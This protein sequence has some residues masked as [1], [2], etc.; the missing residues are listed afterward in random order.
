MDWNMALG[1][2]E[3]CSVCWMRGVHTASG[4]AV[5]GPPRGCWLPCGSVGCKC[6]AGTGSCLP[7]IL[8]AVDKSCWAALRSAAVPWW[9]F[10]TIYRCYLILFT[11]KYGIRHINEDLTQTDRSVITTFLFKIYFILI[12]KIINVNH[13]MVLEGKWFG[14]LVQGL[15]CTAIR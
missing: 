6:P 8:C 5:W 7:M 13:M 3:Y 4:V 15:I 10:D 9:L 12:I 1:V 14:H 2:S 11:C